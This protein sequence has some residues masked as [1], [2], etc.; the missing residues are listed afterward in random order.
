MR[1][2]RT[3]S[4]APY[5]ADMGSRAR[6]GPC[7][8]ISEARSGIRKTV[9]APNRDSTVPETGQEPVARETD[10]RSAGATVP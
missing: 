1:A 3:L 9:V 6:R 10:S 5:S 8:S 4:R 7:L 2:A